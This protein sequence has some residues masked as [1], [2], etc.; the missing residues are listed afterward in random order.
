MCTETPPRTHVYNQGVQPHLHAHIHAPWHLHT[1]LSMVPTLEDTC[2]HIAVN[3]QT[4]TQTHTSK[5]STRAGPC[6][7]HLGPCAQACGHTCTL[8]TT[9]TPTHAFT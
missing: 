6:P 5:V 2:G 3:F 8:D 1:C 7:P 9:Y 4:C